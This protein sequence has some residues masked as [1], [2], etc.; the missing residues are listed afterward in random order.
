MLQSWSYSSSF[1]AVDSWQFTGSNPIQQHLMVCP[2]N[3]DKSQHLEYVGPLPLDGKYAV[4]S[5][6]T[7]VL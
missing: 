7:P 3:Q 1:G 2:F 4:M 5:C 6:K